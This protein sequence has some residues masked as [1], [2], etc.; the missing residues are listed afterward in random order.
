MKVHN[1]AFVDVETTGTDYDKHEIIELALIVARQ[2]ERDGKGPKIEVLGEYE[3]K[4]KPERIQDA[5]EE[6]LRVNGYNETDWIFAADLASV[7]KEFNKK[8]EGCTF[9]SHNLVFDYNFVAKAYQKTGIENNMHYGKLD[10]ISIAF[11]RL[12]DAPQADKFSLKFLCELLKVENTRAHTA[13][14]DTRA[15]VEVYKKL[16]RAV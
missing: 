15:L 1:L 13:L 3:W 2:V 9:V 4:I 16:M 10:T 14:A 6:A 12:Y 5:E 8:A 11:A 7:L